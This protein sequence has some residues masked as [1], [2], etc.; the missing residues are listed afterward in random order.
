MKNRNTKSSKS[1]RPTFQ[2]TVTVDLYPNSSECKFDK[3]AARIAGSNIRL[4]D[5]DNGD[6]TYTMTEAG[7][8]ILI[9]HWNKRLG[10]GM[11]DA[12]IAVT[13]AV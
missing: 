2:A 3:F 5:G 12:T 6:Y 7:L 11:Q 13:A 8:P 10:S 1:F 4:V 9:N